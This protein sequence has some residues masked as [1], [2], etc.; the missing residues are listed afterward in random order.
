[1]KLYISKGQFRSDIEVIL[2]HKLNHIQ[3]KND[4]SNQ[5]F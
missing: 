1:M 5:K 2:I 4:F 3:T